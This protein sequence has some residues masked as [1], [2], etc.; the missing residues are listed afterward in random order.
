MIDDEDGK[1]RRNLVVYSTLVIVVTFLGIQPMQILLKLVGHDQGQVE[2]WKAWA[3]SAAVLMYLKFRFS[4]I[5][6]DQ[7]GL[8]RGSPRPRFLEVWTGFWRGSVEAMVTKDIKMLSDNPSNCILRLVVRS[9]VDK[10]V[11][12]SRALYRDEVRT[13]MTIATLARPTV[14]LAPGYLSRSGVV[15]A[16]VTLASET[17]G[18]NPGL[19]SRPIHIDNIRFHVSRL[20][21][22]LLLVR[23][24]PKAVLTSDEGLQHNFP[25]L[26]ALFAAGCIAYQL[27]CIAWAYWISVAP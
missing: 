26:L 12:Q 19:Q 15:S 23:T 13:E 27:W 22:L 10:V 16:E 20:Q 21:W 8:N 4:K 7:P 25:R 11:E 14:N 3:I 17:V 5:R 24:G 18:D 1:V 9:S 2:A 6:L